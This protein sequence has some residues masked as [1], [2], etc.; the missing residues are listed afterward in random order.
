VPEYGLVCLLDFG[1]RERERLWEVGEQGE[2]ALRQLVQCRNAARA[3]SFDVLS[4]AVQSR[5]RQF[6]LVE[7]N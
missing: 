5:L 2:L 3:G 7:G 4:D 1:Y 6:A